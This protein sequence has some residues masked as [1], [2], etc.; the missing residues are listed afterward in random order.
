MTFRPTL[1]KLS[2]AQSRAAELGLEGTAE[3]LG[4]LRRQLEGFKDLPLQLREKRLRWAVAKLEDTQATMK[5]EL[6]AAKEEK[7]ESFDWDR[8]AMASLTKAGVFIASLALAFR[9]MGSY[10]DWTFTIAA[11][12]GAGVLAV[13]RVVD[14]FLGAGFDSILRNMEDALEDCRDG[15]LSHRER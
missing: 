4:I 2:S 5:K 6:E 9:L 7:K 10:E 15:L 1:R 12:V 14:L 13:N 3:R 11:S 8:R